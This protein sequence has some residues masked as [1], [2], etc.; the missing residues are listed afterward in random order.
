MKKPWGT[1]EFNLAKVSE[2]VS[3][4]TN[5]QN[6]PFWTEGNIFLLG[7][8]PESHHNMIISSA[9]IIRV[10]KSTRIGMGSTGLNSD[11]S[12]WLTQGMEPPWTEDIRCTDTRQMPIS[13]SS[14]QP[15]PTFTHPCLHGQDRT[16]ALEQLGSG[17]KKKLELGPLYNI[18]PT[19]GTKPMLSWWKSRLAVCLVH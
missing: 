8:T 11:I 7:Y 3:D 12:T 18:V 4:S 9:G 14:R 10:M 1:E 17:N 2:L 13:M 6:R 16:E 5:I 19:L 15:F